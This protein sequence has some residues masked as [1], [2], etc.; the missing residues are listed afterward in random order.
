MCFKWYKNGIRL[1]VADRN[2]FVVDVEGNIVHK[3]R[4]SFVWPK[5]RVPMFWKKTIRFDHIFVFISELRD[6]K[7]ECASKS[8]KKNKITIIANVQ[9]RKQK[10]Y[11]PVYLIEW[12]S[13][14][15]NKNAF[16]GHFKCRQIAFDVVDSER[17]SIWWKPVKQ[18]KN[19]STATL[20]WNII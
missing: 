5:N 7:K 19:R 3:R 18:L 16:N 6:N 15:E 14:R 8:T 12:W 9:N 2:V 4:S 1:L 13:A 11:Q 20:L 10:N 17:F